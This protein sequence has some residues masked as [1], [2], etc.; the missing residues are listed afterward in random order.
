MRKIFFILGLFIVLLSACRSSRQVVQQSITD[1][2]TVS[3]RE[4]EKVF[5]IPGD[6]VVLLMP[7]QVYQDRFIPAT[8]TAETKRA[9][10]KLEI[11]ARGEVKATA[12]CKELEEKVTVLEKTISNYKSEVTEYQVKESLF[13][14]A[15]NSAKRTLRTIIY[16]VAILLGLYAY[17]RFRS[18]LKSFVNKLIQ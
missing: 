3:Y 17:F 15:L 10:V 7:V 11:N 13:N 5:Q 4:V 18:G 16:V 8:Q 12:I 2:T 6:T 1:S 14:Q 9:S